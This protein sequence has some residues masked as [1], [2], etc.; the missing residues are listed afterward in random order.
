MKMK[1]SKFII[2]CISICCLHYLGAEKQITEEQ[3]KAI[4]ALTQNFNKAPDF[5]LK[6][7]EGGTVTLSELEGKVVLLNFWATWCGPCRMEIP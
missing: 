6:N 5:T 2:I 1:H 7:I 3:K 4:V